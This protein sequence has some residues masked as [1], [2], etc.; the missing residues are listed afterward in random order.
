MGNLP[1]K[2][3]LHLPERWFNFAFIINGLISD[4]GMFEYCN[5][6]IVNGLPI[7]V[8]QGRQ[9][10]SFSHGTQAFE[11]ASTKA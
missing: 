5:T 9:F 4:F 11:G 1:A 8:K 3:P 10:T 7:F 6:F 2:L